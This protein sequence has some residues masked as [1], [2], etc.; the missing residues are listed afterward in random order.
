[1]ANSKST[2]QPTRRKAAAPKR[3]GRPSF[4]PSLEQRER[5]EILVAGGQSEEDIARVIGVARGTLREHFADE[6]STGRAKKRAEVLVAQ[7]RTA[8]AGNA[9]A[10]EKFL[11]KGEV[12]ELP[13]YRQP[14]EEKLGKKEQ[15]LRDAHEPDVGTSM[16]SLM[17]QRLN[18]RPN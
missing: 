13:E 7:F 11:K 14:K 12:P 18:S 2:K 6:L 5:V 3:P 16:G 15:A 4:V 9:S 8:I 10:Q 1:M 17:A